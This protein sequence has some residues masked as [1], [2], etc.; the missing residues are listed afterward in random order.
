MYA[1]HWQSEPIRRSAGMVLT[2]F[3]SLVSIYGLHRLSQGIATLSAAQG[4]AT[5]QQDSG[6]G[7]NYTTFQ[8]LWT[9]ARGVP[10]NY[11]IFATFTAL[12]KSRPPTTQATGGA[13]RKTRK[14]NAKLKKK[15]QSDHP[16]R[17]R[18]CWI[19]PP[20]RTLGWP[21]PPNGWGFYRN[22]HN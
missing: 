20:P 17:F 6:G 11:F 4:L 19:K 8:D 10:A 5:N 15:P 13:S 16:R 9:Q 22:P 21:G 1:A 14:H 3:L 2:L 18:R 7:T 12:S